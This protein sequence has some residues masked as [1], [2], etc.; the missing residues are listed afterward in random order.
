MPVKDKDLRPQKVLDVY[1]TLEALILFTD[2]TEDLTMLSAV[3]LLSAK[4]ILLSN[5][6]VDKTTAI[7]EQMLEELSKIKRLETP[8]N[9]A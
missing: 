1:K 8:K 6:G 5:H 9:I 4:Q 3:M 7:F 2:V